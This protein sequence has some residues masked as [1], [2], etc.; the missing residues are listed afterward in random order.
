MLCKLY[1][2]KA[3]KKKN[4]KKEKS[5]LYISNSLITISKPLVWTPDHVFASTWISNR[6]PQLNM[7]ETPSPPPNPKSIPAELQCMD[8]CS[9][10]CPDH[11]NQGH[12]SL[13]FSHPTL[14]WISANL[15]S[16]YLQNVSQTQPLSTSS[17]AATLVWA[18]IFTRISEWPPHWPSD[19]STVTPLQAPLHAPLHISASGFY[20]LR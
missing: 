6:H 12:L 17:A 14:K 16:S 2:D 18:V 8:H 10:I 15:V 3:I 20:S 4:S 9:L 1:L 7:S 13:P 11:K 5:Q 19:F